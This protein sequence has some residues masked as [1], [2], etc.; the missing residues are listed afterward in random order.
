MGP[1]IVTDVNL[2]SIAGI[3][4]GDEMHDLL[5]EASTCLE[6]KRGRSPSNLWE[7]VSELGKTRHLLGDV[8]RSMGRVLTKAEK[9][10][11]LGSAS[12]VYLALRYGLGPLIS[13]AENIV[14]SLDKTVGTVRIK[15]KCERLLFRE[16]TAQLTWLHDY[17]KTTADAK[18]SERFF[19]KAITIDETDA[20]RLSRAGFT[21]KGLVTLPWELTT[22]S[23][24]ADW[25]FNIGDYLGAL[26]PALGWK[27]LGSCLS[28]EHEK[29]YTVTCTGTHEVAGTYA[30]LAPNT[31]TIVLET[32]EHWR[33][34]TLSP[35]LVK[36]SDFGLFD[37]GLR[38][39][40]AFTLL[41]QRVARLGGKNKSR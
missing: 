13:D 40:D 4:S 7:T 2:A 26:A 28:V 27:Q 8:A 24:V 6:N 16:A 31:G 36:K 29:K 5:V 33:Q 39:A 22:L 34:G 3:L 17:V 30:V 32:K 19:V 18:T 23:F 38:D 37:G 21:I 12:D 41:G 25:F 15:Q 1:R 11:K 9:L 14:K 35:G 10:S 20:T